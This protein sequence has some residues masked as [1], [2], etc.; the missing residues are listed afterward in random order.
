[1]TRPTAVRR[2]R[3]FRAW[4]SHKVIVTRQLLKRCVSKLQNN[5]CQL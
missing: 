4:Y 2:F 3:L 5:C 1:M